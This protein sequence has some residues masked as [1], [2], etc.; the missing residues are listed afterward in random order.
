MKASRLFLALSMAAS[1]VAYAAGSA[2]SIQVV[3]PYVRAAPPGARATGAF[4]LLKNGGAADAKLVKAESTAAKTVELHT[5]IDNHG[6]MEMRQ[7]PEIGIK[8]KGETALK[9]GSYHIMMIDPTANLKPGD[10]VAITLRFADGSSKQVEAPV[11][12]PEAPSGMPM[13][14][15]HH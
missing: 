12:M 7:V 15:M 5:H 9:P 3:D 1:A 11:K 4:M 8:A 10:K 2:D 6:V 14:H 13:E